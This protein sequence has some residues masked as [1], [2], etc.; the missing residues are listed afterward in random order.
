[1]DINSNIREDNDEEDAEDEYEDAFESIILS[2]IVSR[3]NLIDVSMLYSN[4]NINN[5]DSEEEEL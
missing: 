5:E 3:R 2:N 1:M 4:Q